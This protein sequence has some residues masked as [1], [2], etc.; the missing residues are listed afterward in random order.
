MANGI[1]YFAVKSIGLSKING[2]KP[3]T[4]KDAARHNLREIQAEAL[5]KGRIDTRQTHNNWVMEGPSNADGVVSLALKIA[6]K[7]GVILSNKRHDYCQAIELIF[8]LPDKSEIESTK[9]FLSCLEWAKQEYEL[10]LLSAVTHMDESS[11]H[12]HILFMPLNSHGEYVGSKPLGKLETK[13][14]IESFFSKVALPAGLKRQ[15]AKMRG[16]AKQVAVDIILDRCRLYG[17]PDVNGPLWPIFEAAIK[18]DPVPSLEALNID[19]QTISNA[20]RTLLNEQSKTLGIGTKSPIPIGIEQFSS[21]KQTLS[22]V[23][24]DHSSV[25]TKK[26]ESCHQN[27]LSRLQLAGLVDQS[28]EEMKLLKGGGIPQVVVCEDITEDSEIRVRDEYSH[29]LSAWDD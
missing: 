22:S 5:S 9:Y 23:E 24:I 21:A 10:P 25:T 27:K 1:A 28:K 20:Y 11:P 16:Q 7:A 15:G 13:K 3:C 2:R 8:S 19:R 26:K 12:C 4:L 6:T 18:K 29:D 14:N 17:L